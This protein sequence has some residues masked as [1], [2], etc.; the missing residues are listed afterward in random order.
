[1]LDGG[2]R[3]IA[4]PAQHGPANGERTEDGFINA[5]VTGFVLVHDSGTALYVS[6]DN[7]SLRLVTEIHDRIGRIDVAVLHAGAA[8][9]PGKFNGRPLSLTSDRAAG[10]AEILD[11]QRV[12]VAHDDGWA[13][14]TEGAD[15]VRAAFA[16]VGISDVLVDAPLGHWSF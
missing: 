5:D 14:F 16:R 13:H 1:L 7:A 9:V 6:G 11:A 15:D 12:V 10:A 3:V 4:V 2:V 8:S